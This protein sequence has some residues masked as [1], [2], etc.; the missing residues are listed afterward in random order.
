[1]EEVQILP[2]VLGV[3][4]LILFIKAVIMVTEQTAY[5]IERFGQ[6]IRVAHSG[7]GGIIPFV[8]RNAAVVNLRIQQL[9]VILRPKPW[10]MYL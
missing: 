2:I 7:L 5:V 4:A 6:F 9:N 8:D 1:M 10:M 3:I